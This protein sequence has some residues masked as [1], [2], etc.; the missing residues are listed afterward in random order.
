LY[1]PIDSCFT[2]THSNQLG[3]GVWGSSMVRRQSYRIDPCVLRLYG[4]AFSSFDIAEAESFQVVSSVIAAWADIASAMGDAVAAE[5]SGLATSG[6][7][8]VSGV[9]QSMNVG[10][11]WMLANCM[12]SAAY[13]GISLGPYLHFLKFAP[14]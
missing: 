9:V 1:D 3:I 5:G 7:T 8:T 11:F 4:R 14:F 10:Y 6:L 12:T 13:V 2:F